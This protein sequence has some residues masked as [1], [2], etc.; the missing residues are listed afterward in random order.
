MLQNSYL[1]AKIG[2]DTAE[3]ERNNRFCQPTLSDVSEL[4][5]ELDAREL[6]GGEGQVVGL[7]G[8]G[9]KKGIQS[10]YK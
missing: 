9:R 7:Q 4:V 1:V 8:L 5:A 3:N 10:L 2:A 6:A